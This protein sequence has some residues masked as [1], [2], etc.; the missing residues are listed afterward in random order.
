MAAHPSTSPL[1]SGQV[2]LQFISDGSGASFYAEAASDVEADFDVMESHK[3]FQ[4]ALDSLNASGLCHTEMDGIL[5][6][7]MNIEE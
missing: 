7:K 3:Q 4:N 5:S 1:N 2:G 6:H